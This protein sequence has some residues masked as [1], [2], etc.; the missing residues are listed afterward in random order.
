M[1]IEGIKNVPQYAHE[2]RFIVY[3]IVNGECW[4]WGA[5]NDAGKA[6]SAAK[7]IG[8]EVMDRGEMQ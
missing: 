7:D 3:R 6:V 2:Y 8:G 5:W 4:F 1:N